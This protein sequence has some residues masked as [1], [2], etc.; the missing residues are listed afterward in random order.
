MPQLQKQSYP[1]FPLLVQAKEAEHV[2]YTIINIKYAHTFSQ[3]FL[4]V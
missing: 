1:F 3:G 2:S 4:T